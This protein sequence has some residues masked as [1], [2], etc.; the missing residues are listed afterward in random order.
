MKRRFR[1]EFWVES[2]RADDSVFSVARDVL[3][4]LE[5]GLVFSE[6]FSIYQMPVVTEEHT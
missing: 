5:C 3:D 1:V 4:S 2:D 6:P